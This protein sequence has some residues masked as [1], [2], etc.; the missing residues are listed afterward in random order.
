MEGQRVYHKI[1]RGRTK[2]YIYIYICYIY[3]DGSLGVFRSPSERR[4]RVA[5][6]AASR[7]VEGN[8][9]LLP[10]HISY[11]HGEHPRG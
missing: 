2:L 4:K 9:L 3:P 7:S 11:D 6:E 5:I 1:K 10:S 8:I